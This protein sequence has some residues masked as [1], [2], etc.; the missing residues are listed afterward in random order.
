MNYFGH[1]AVS[2]WSDASPARALGAMLPD[3][4]GMLGA[5]LADGS[6]RE[7]ADGIA[8][9]HATDHVFHTLAP[10]VALMKDLDAQ[11]DQLGCARGPRRAVAHVGVEL[12]LD[13][14][15]V[16]DEAYRAIY[17]AAL[18]C[19]PARVS[20]QTADD[21][22]RFTILVD[23]LRGYGVP[24]DLRDPGAITSRLA[25]ILAPRPLLAPSPS[26]LRAIGTALADH[27]RRVT[28]ATETVLRGLRVQIAQLRPAATRD[29]D[30]RE[31]PAASSPASRR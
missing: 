1:A 18:A 20:W 28:I 31:N 27:Q 14:V 3:F 5:K 2:S 15:L 6:D 7:I 29:A 21:A 11:L 4:A 8:L 19:D 13:G 16:A 22:A 23:R 30:G 12:L 9:H 26:D 24:D 17:S 25:R 10:V